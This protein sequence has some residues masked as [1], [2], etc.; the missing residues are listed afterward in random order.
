MTD[1]IKA[2]QNKAIY[3]FEVKNVRVLETHIS[4]VILTGTYA[5]KIKKPVNFG[6]LDYTDLALRKKYCEDEIKFNQFLAPKIYL[7][8]VVITGSLENPKIDGDGPVIE[9]A[10]KMQEF[11]QENLLTKVAKRNELTED[12]IL[13]IADDMAWFHDQ[14][15]KVPSNVYFGAPEEVYKP[16]QQN[17]DQ[18]RPLLKNADELAQLDR[19]EN[20]A[21]QEFAKLKNVF[22]ARKQN[23]F[24]R[25]CH[26]DIHL[27]NIVLINNKPVIFDC[28]EFNDKFRFTDTMADLGFMAMDLRDKNFHA[29][30]NRL[31]NRYMSR[32]GDYE[33]LKILKFYEAYRA[34]VRAK[35]NLL[36]LQQNKS[37]DMRAKNKTN[38][39][40]CAKLAGSYL[41]SKPPVLYITHG[42][43]CSGK[44]TISRYLAKQFDA[45]HIRSDVERKRLF[46]RSMETK[47]P[48]AD[49]ENMYSKTSN[50]KTY[51]RLKQLAKL[52]IQSGYSVIVDATFL[53]HK[54]RDEYHTLAKQLNV[55]FKIIHTFAPI[56][57]LKKWIVEREKI[58]HDPSEATLSVLEK[59]LEAVEPLTDAEKEFTI[60]VDTSKS[61][62]ARCKQ[63]LQRLAWF[64]SSH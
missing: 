20:W 42:V 49:I 60:C 5:Y 46:G 23:G 14:I 1:L 3:D 58:H 50:E 9:Y 40:S 38:Y 15:D 18:M 21:K 53:L 39:H 17:F 63:L 32:S 11:S 34:V 13:Q 8:V 52:I 43:S 6:F 24:I 7:G 19:L 12:I 47:T 22:A 48:A 28:I 2:L 45:I 61:F 44:S 56:P 41:S 37:N 54:G 10:V 55:Q 30:A 16:V 31:I 62:C 59:Q 35:I 27:G 29:L 4:W 33:G 51:L 57:Q 64:F 25:A 26:G 36:T